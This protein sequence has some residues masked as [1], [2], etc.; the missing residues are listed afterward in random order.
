MIGSLKKVKRPVGA[1]VFVRMVQN[2]CGVIKLKKFDRVFEKYDR[3]IEIMKFDKSKEIKE[4]LDLQGNETVLDIGGGTGKL[5]AYLSGHC[6]I[7]YVLDESQGMLSMVKEATNIIPVLGDALNTDF[8][9]ESIDVITVSDVLH[10]IENQDK[11][12]EEIH[13]LLK[14]GGKLVILD[15]ERNHIKTRILGMFEYILFGKLYYRT[16]EETMDLLKE[17]FTITKSAHKEYYY[18]IRGEKNV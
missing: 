7:V 13:R 3:F 16:S 4:M 2:P 12:I 1:K 17:K 11:L 6:K 5:A 9:G 8:D 18:I 15:F 10:H 14:K